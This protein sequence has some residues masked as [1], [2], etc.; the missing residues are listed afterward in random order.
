MEKQK[1]KFVLAEASIHDINKQ[2]KINLLV[3]VLVLFLLGLNSLYFIRDK[4]VFSAVL[5]VLMIFLLFLIA[6]SR[7]ILKSRK[8]Q[9][10]E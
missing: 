10:S 8:Q 6:K 3:I 4:S 9:L 7:D 1:S 5:I 2:L